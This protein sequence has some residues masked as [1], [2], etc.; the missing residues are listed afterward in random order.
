MPEKL[1]VY[2]AS[3]CVWWDSIDKAGG[4]PIEGCPPLPCCPHCGGVLFQQEESA[5]WKGV[6]R[7]EVEGHPGYRKFVEWWRGKCF[8]TYEAARAAY[9]ARAPKDNDQG[10]SG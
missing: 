8:P 3:H 1:I 10:R 4:I 9:A 7:Y 5:W 2:G 6:D